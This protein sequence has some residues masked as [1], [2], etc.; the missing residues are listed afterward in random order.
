MS[1]E[2]EQKV[3]NLEFVLQRFIVNTEKSI[4]S[5]AEDRKKDKADYKAMYK[6]HAEQNRI[7]LKEHKE[8]NRIDLKEHKEENRIALEKYKEE[9]KIFLKEFRQDINKK[10]GDLANKMGTLIE[11]IFMPGVGPSVRR[12]F[13]SEIDFIGIHVKKQIKKLDLK[14]EFDVVAT[15]EDRVYVV[16]V[17]SSPDKEKIDKFI[18]TVL[19]RFRKLFPEYDAKK[20]TPIMGSLRFD[21]DIISYATEKGVYAMGYREWEYLDVL[22]FDEVQSKDEA[23][24]K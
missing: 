22:N 14:G 19:P 12:Y 9:N 8:Q 23:E 24:P 18:Q 10:W 13:D 1:T 2:V 11:D 5:L 17:K 7:A 4:E 21:D 16:D 20:L 6:N 15:D 3:D